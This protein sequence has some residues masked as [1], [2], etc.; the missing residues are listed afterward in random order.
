MSVHK[1]NVKSVLKDFSVEVHA[2]QA[3]ELDEDAILSKVKKA[4]GADYSGNTAN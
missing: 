3:S 4:S 1:A 2:E